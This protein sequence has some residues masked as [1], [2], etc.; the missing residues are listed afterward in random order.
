MLKVKSLF[1]FLKDATYDFMQSSVSSLRGIVGAPDTPKW[2][3]VLFGGK[4][5]CYLY[6]IIIFSFCEIVYFIYYRF[7]LNFEI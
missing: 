7:S 3:S 1:F 6:K 5:I 4:I 2:N